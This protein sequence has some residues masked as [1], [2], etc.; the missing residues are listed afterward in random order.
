MALTNL[1]VKLIKQGEQTLAPLTVSEAVLVKHND[2]VKTLHQVLQVK[3]ETANNG[4]DESLK[5]TTEG[6]MLSISHAQTIKANSA[7]S[8]ILIRHDN[9]GHIIE[10]TPV[11]KLTVNIQG[12]KYV[13]HDGSEESMVNLGD[14]FIANGDKIMLNWNNLN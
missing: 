3:L 6:H 4:N 1:A 7:P 10:T 8:P 9:K 13:E 5:V 11:Q 2:S 14:D 12:T